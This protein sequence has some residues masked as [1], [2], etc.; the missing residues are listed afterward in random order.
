MTS[1]E[2]ECFVCDHPSRKHEQKEDG[3][4][5]CLVPGCD[6]NGFEEEEDAY[7]EE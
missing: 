1:Q 6:C 5:K 2:D 3:A 7:L 4:G